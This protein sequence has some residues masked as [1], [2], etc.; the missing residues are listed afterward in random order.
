M[1]IWIKEIKNN[2]LLRDYV[3]E[4]HDEDTRTHKVFKALEGGCYELDLAV[5]QWLEKN[6]TEFK[7]IGRT[8][9]YQD[10]FVNETLDFDYLDFHVIEED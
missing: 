7:R 2:K 8:R 10:S 3:Y 1:R 4:D 6:I 9:F 5:P